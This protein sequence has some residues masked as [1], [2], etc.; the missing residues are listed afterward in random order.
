[1]LYGAVGLIVDVLFA[2]L[3]GNWYVEIVNEIV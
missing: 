2:E 1:M 3:F